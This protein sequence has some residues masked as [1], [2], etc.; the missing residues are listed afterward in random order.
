MPNPTRLIVLGAGRVGSAIALDL[1][2]DSDVDVTVVDRDPGRA[3]VFPAEADLRFQPA[4]LGDAGRLSE[5][6]S[7][8]DLV[9]GA[10]PGWMG[11]RTLQASLEA[12]KNV[13]DISFFEEDPFTLNDLARTN[14]VTAVVDCGVAPG[15]GNLVLGRQEQE[16]DHISSFTCL[17]GGLPQDPKPP[18]N[19]VA[20]YSPS[21]VIE[22]YTR[23][24]RLVRGG[25]VVTVPAL[26][27]VEEIVF[28]GIGT[29]EA[30]N[31]DGLRTLLR[32]TSI[33][34]LTEKTLRYPGFCKL[35]SV[36]HSAGFFDKERDADG[37]VIRPR[38]VTEKLL[39]DQWFQT[40]EDHD[41]TVMRLVTKGVRNGKSVRVTYD[42]YDQFDK[43]QRISSMART[44]GYPCAAVA[45][46]IIRGDYA[47][48][49][50]I[51][52]ELIGADKAAYDSIFA[53]LE[54]RGVVFAVVEEEL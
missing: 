40:A 12:G 10:V 8:F 30:F 7:D 6:V 44:T 17:V 2:S 27:E 3:T 38:E 37:T 4:D 41:I 1:A 22:M 28:P 45:R 29:L 54:Q 47:Q 52:P 50:I 39:T 34:D 5:L 25:K 33:P 11:Y 15:L 18:W 49:G 24:A 20:P 23:P 21:D 53:D 35:I 42:L 16:F 51:S 36:F 48:P 31:T 26:T 14:G 13:V 46:L 9:I 32:K 43:Q 19:Y